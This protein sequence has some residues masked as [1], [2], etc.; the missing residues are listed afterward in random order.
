MAYSSEYYREFKLVNAVVFEGIGPDGVQGDFRMYFID[1]DFWY[2]LDIY[3]PESAYDFAYTSYYNP[4]QN[5][6]RIFVVGGIN[7]LNEYIMS[8]NE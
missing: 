7:N 1:F 4:D 3:L 2:Q 8:A 5:F 6:T